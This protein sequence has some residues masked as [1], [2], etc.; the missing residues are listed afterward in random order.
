MAALKNALV[1]K[2]LI[3]SLII[4]LFLVC[5]LISAAASIKYLFWPASGQDFAPPAS[6]DPPPLFHSKK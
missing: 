6:C 4:A 3:A 5:T 2:E 1:S